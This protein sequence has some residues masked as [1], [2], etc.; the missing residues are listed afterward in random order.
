MGVLHHFDDNYA[1]NLFN[2][3]RGALRPDRTIGHAR[4][5]FGEGAA[6]TD[7]IRREPGL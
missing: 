3:A 6:E 7:A 4:R 5:L 2:L 1:V